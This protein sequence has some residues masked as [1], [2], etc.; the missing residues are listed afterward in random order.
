MGKK[1]SSK[2]LLRLA[3]LKGYKNGQPLLFGSSRS[4]SLFREKRCVKRD[5][6]INR[7]MKT[8][9]SKLYSITGVERS[10]TVHSLQWT[11]LC[12]HLIK[13][14]TVSLVALQGNSN[15]LSSPNADRAMTLYKKISC[16]VEMMLFYRII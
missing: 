6:I 8:G 16:S 11:L 2:D 15:V 14:N 13:L 9:R 3:R 7:T 4:T 1:A 10:L 5:E 12:S